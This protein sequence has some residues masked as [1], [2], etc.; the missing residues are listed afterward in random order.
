[1]EALSSA[2]AWGSGRVLR[3]FSGASASL[4][5]GISRMSGSALGAMKFM[6]VSMEGC[7]GAAKAALSGRPTPALPTGRLG[8]PA[9]LPAAA[10]LDGCAALRTRAESGAGW[11]DA[12]GPLVEEFALS[13]EVGISGGLAM[14]DA[15]FPG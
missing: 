8:L 12:A 7:I 10:R 3:T 6:P 5:S 2:S 11:V 1:M 4:L 9:A 14:G 13:R 15:G